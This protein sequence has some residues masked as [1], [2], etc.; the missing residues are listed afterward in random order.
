MRYPNVEGFRR[1]SHGFVG[2]LQGASGTL[3]FYASG[4]LTSHRRDLRQKDQ[5]GFAKLPRPSCTCQLNQAGFE[6]GNI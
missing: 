3:T 6:S 1:L 5:K 2:L 4:F